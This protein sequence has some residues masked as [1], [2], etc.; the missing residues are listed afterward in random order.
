[1]ASLIEEEAT[2]KADRH[3]IAS[4]F[5]NRLEEKCRRRL[6][7]RYYMRPVSI[8]AGSTTKT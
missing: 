4:V 3:K 2:A 7:R 5:Y 1:M 8:K 6:T